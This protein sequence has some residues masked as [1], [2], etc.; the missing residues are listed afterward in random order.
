MDAQHKTCS[1]F[2]WLFLSTG[3][4]AIVGA[5]YTWG[6]GPLRE[7]RDLSAA[8]IPWADL[9]LTGPLSLLAAFG[10]IRRRSW[11]TLLG[12]LCC[13]IYLFGSLLV[14]ITL[15]WQ[16]PP[17]PLQ[18]ALP[19]LFGIGLGTAYPVWVLHTTACWRTAG[20]P[21][22]TDCPILKGFQDQLQPERVL[23]QTDSTL[24]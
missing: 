22:Q 15:L 23:I 9:L 7:A 16:G 12:L 6:A 20:N 3:I 13:G 24:Q 5:L 19:P 8:L 4:F 2:S 11:G 18:L 10:I 1:T 17:Y 21:G 14:Y